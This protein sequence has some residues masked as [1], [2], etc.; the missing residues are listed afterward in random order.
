MMQA[1]LPK[2]KWLYKSSPDAFRKIVANE[3]GAALF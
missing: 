1:D 3:G 2:E